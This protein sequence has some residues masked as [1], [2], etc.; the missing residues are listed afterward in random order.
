MNQEKTG[1]E[2]EGNTDKMY[3]FGNIVISTVRFQYEL[4]IE[5]PQTVALDLK[6]PKI[7]GLE[8]PAKEDIINAML[9]D[10][11]T[12]SL[13]DEFTLSSFAEYL[14]DVDVTE[15]ISTANYYGAEIEFKCLSCS[16]E[17]ISFHFTGWTAYNSLSVRFFEFLVTISLTEPSY[18]KLNTDKLSY[19]IQSGQYEVITGNYAPGGWEKKDMAGSFI[20]AINDQ[21]KQDDIKI[22]SYRI[23]SDAEIQYE[24]YDVNDIKNY[25]LDEAHTYVKFYFADSLYGYVILCIDSDLL[26]T[27]GRLT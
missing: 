27:R 2:E 15:D 26:N 5:I 21:S 10:V 8:D 11:A 14:T 18:L 20:Q 19:A 1:I 6:Y 24:V 4:G 9:L 7:S 25:A 3:E 13:G 16:D 17:Y 22:E 23:G 12:K